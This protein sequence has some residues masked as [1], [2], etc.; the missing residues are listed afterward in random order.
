VPSP[1]HKPSLRQELHA[2]SDE[3]QLIDQDVQALTFA[4]IQK[5]R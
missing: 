4:S 2:V 5:D 3:L 1:L